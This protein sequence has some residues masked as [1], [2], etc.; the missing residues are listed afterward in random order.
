MMYSSGGIMK[1][2]KEEFAG[3]NLEN[4]RYKKGLGFAATYRGCGL[5]GEGYD[6]AGAEITIE[7]DGSI[8]IHSD[9][10]EMGQGLR[11]AHAQVA[12]EVLGVRLDRIGMM[13]TD[14]SSILDAGPTV[15][16]GGSLLE[17]WQL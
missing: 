3:F 1:V 6:V 15:A 8:Q 14:T 17:A 2:K 7:K 11:T 13:E 5:G 4:H 12:A 9:M 16:P 10:V